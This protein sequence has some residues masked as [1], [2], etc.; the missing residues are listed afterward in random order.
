MTAA[1]PAGKLNRRI[2]LQR[3]ATQSGAPGGVGLGAYAEIGKR[4]A[5]VMP[6]GGRQVQEHA[7]NSESAD[8]KVAVRSCSLTRSLTTDDRIILNG[9]AYGIVYVE[10]ANSQDP[11]V[12]FQCDSRRE[13]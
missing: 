5:A 9:K 13:N 11:M 6:M 12:W 3:R 1:L 8:I 10:P 7:L 4:W 2:A